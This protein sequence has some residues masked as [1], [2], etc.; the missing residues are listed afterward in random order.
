M[1]RSVESL[2]TIT[3]IALAPLLLPVACTSETTPPPPRARVGGAPIVLDGGAAR[4][5]VRL[6]PF[7]LSISNGAGKTVLKTI[8]ADPHVAGDGVRAYGSIGATHHETEFLSS[9]IEGWD[10]VRGTDAPWLHASAVAAV[11]STAT[12]ASLD[13]FDPTSRDSE[14]TT[15]HVD[16]SVDGAHVSLEAF[17][18]G[19]P[20][21]P[22]PTAYASGPNEMGLSFSLAD[23]E[24]FY[25]LGER[26]V[27]V[28]HRGQHYECWTEEGGIG[29]GESRTP[30]PDNPSPNGQG[31][32]H[33]P[34]PFTISSKGYG[35]WQAT[36]F[37]TGFSL[38]SDDAHVARLYAE[39]PALHLHL[40]VHDDPKATLADYTAA[41][42]RAR[43]P[44][45]WVFG[46]R[47]RVDRTGKTVG[48]ETDAQA[49]RS[50]HVPTT[51]V[52]DALHFLPIDS[53]R[54]RE[55]ELADWTTLMHQQGFKA[56]G[57]FNAYVSISD[58]NAQSL[59]DYGRA[60]DLFLRLDDGSEFQSF[61]ISA[62]GQKITT[63]D[64]TNPEAVA[65]FQSLEEQA[66]S[67]GY[68]GWM[69]DFGEY[70]PQRA[71]AWDGRSGW[72]LHDAFPLLQQR[73][74]T[75]VMTRARG[76]DWM[77]FARSG[78]AGTQ[79][80]AP[81]V[82]SGDPDGSFDEAKGL[83]AQLRGGVNA[84]LSGI[85]FWGS[86]IS[87]YTCVNDPPP[88]KE[89][90]LRWAEFGALSS[91]MHDE[92]A[93]AQKPADAPP[94]WTLFS[95]AETT[96]VYA[97]YASLHTRL[98]PYL[99]MAAQEAVA[100][101][102]PVMRHPLLMNPETPQAWSETI[103]YWFGPSL[104]AAPVVHRGETS[105]E[106]WLP[107][108]TWFDWWTMAP[109]AGG[110]T[111]TRDAPLDVLPLWIK[112]GAIVPMLD[113]AVE[114][115]APDTSPDVISADDRR[116]ILD[117]RAAIDG[118]TGI[119]T[120]RMIDGTTF[121]VQLTG[122]AVAL[123]PTFTT[124]T[125]ASKLATCDDCGTIDA[126]AGGATRVRVTTKPT[127]EESIVAGGL[128]LR[129]GRAPVATRFRW[130]VAVAP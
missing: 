3:A 29:G 87:G 20:R 38:G 99:M 59:V 22:G 107:P 94:K 93:C 45:P 50:H 92:N 120:A 67:L 64:L 10:H 5:E 71:K 40:W 117:V 7:G 103:D 36:T 124:V 18:V 102:L 122:A 57:Y 63:I 114:T 74:T 25:G 115:L 90:Y 4:V 58:P 19:A 76:D 88:N 46:P 81:V 113:P 125:D 123:P 53:S 62:G 23:D 56:I 51:M 84:G 100:R 35:L 31:M 47:R 112:S 129:V 85:A 116:G 11:R 109:I 49:L 52:D 110:T 60:H 6:D 43:L 39:E 32:T 68:D 42:G 9:L 41:T 82:W 78:A 75:D 73:A 127:K 21:D 1:L 108:G 55:A 86:D 72:E 34:V 13:L 12:T 130:D 111:V 24:R 54:G 119:G 14:R 98:N 105:R 66:L 27:T 128:I 70:V 80:F 15:I 106:A 97:R 30:G 17:V 65:W 96:S 48:D 33:L 101:G 2:R 44:A 28:D 77:Y 91:D 126:I 16:L 95:D 61:V 121:Y 69:L 104:Y 79:A 26:Y 8:D 83:P 37:R 89:L 118:K